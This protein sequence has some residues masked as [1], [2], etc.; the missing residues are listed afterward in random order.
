MGGSKSKENKE[1]RSRSASGHLSRGTKD[2]NDSLADKDAAAN[3]KASASSL[4]AAG[5]SSSGADPKTSPSLGRSGTKFA[6]V[7]R[8]TISAAQGQNLQSYLAATAA[9]PQPPEE[10]LNKMFEETL[11]E[12]NLSA[13]K[14]ANM[15]LFTPEKKWMLV[16]GHRREKVHVPPLMRTFDC[17]P[18][19]DRALT[20]LFLCPSMD[21]VRTRT[22][23]RTFRAKS[24]CSG[25]TRTTSYCPLWSCL[26]AL[27]LSDGSTSS[28]SWM[29]STLC[30][31]T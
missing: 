12:L 8:I 6:N 3:A 15:M 31:T 4:G 19:E 11:S 5:A 17:S 21:R 26:C 30:W 14:R 27:A 2:S 7:G 16:Q 20:T 1:V 23:R 28:L 13:E 24:T 29:V 18:H 10:E 25:T 9:E 22:P